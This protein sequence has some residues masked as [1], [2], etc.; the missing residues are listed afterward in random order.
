MNKNL[1]SFL[2]GIII[3]SPLSVKADFGDADFPAGIF[4]DGP[5]SYH[6]AWCRY[7]KNKCRVRFQDDAMWVEG[8]GGIYRSQFLK[9]RY[10][11]D[12][13]E[14]YNYVTYKDSNG[15]NR[16]ALFLFTNRKAQGEFI[17]GFFRWKDQ[18]SKPIPNFRLPN[19]QGPQDTQGKDD[20]LN[21]YDNPPIEDWSIKSTEKGMKGKINCDSSV[22]KNSKICQ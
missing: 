6:D 11:W 17:R 9:Y 13:N 21:P 8:Q 14:F 2:I 4:N 15:Q 18:E 16:V 5:K 1:F 12:G 3:L 10:D 22:W 20:G 19:S 7:I